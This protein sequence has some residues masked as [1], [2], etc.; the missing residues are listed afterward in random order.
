MKEG[1]T[2][3]NIDFDIRSKKVCVY[4]ED[5]QQWTQRH[6][7]LKYW[8]SLTKQNQIDFVY[9]LKDDFKDKRPCLNFKPT[10]N[11]IYVTNTEDVP[12]KQMVLKC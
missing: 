3:L 11:M 10:Y 9:D 8:N 5:D 2:V 4:P 7:N 12:T 1:Y 6:A